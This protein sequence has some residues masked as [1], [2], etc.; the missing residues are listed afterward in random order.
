MIVY[1]LSGDQLTE[2]AFSR[3][4]LLVSRVR[5]FFV[6]ALAL[7]SCPF[8]TFLHTMGEIEELVNAD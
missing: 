6:L 5:G 2:L 8:S 1:C 7:F 3:V 4:N